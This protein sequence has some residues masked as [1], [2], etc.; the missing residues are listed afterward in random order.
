[1]NSILDLLGEDLYRKGK[2]PY[3][4]VNDTDGQNDEEAAKEAWHKHLLRNESIITDL[5]H[6]QFKSTVCC[7]SCPR[8]SV[9]FD[10]SMTILLPIPSKKQ[11]I[12]FFFIPYKIKENYDNYC[13]EVAV[14][15]TDSVLL[16]R[17]ALHEKY[18]LECNNFVIAEVCDNEF[19]QFTNGNR[20]VEHINYYK[21]V[22]LL[23]E[24]NPAFPRDEP[25]FSA[26]KTDNNNGFD[27][28]ITK[29]VLE[30]Q[31]QNSP[32]TTKYGYY[33]PKRDST[34]PRLMWVEKAWT[35][36]DLHFEI[37][38]Y[39]R[40]IIQEWMEWTCPNT[41]RKPKLGKVDLRKELLPFPY[42]PQNWPQDQDFDTDEF[43]K[44]SDEEAYKCCF[45]N[46]VS[47]GK[48][49]DL[50]EWS[51]DEMPYQVCFK[52]VKGSYD[53]CEYCSK[54]RCHSCQ[55]PFC[56]KTT[57]GEVLKRL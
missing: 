18:G 49:P 1:M 4:E 20:T 41:E 40:Q 13:C 11:I 3:V 27:E 54:T 5:F 15:D 50:G 31:I 57:I 30:N 34:L 45:P 23:Y 42:R 29:L 16:L 32:N 9:T 25:V 55:V 51:I 19:V 6:G 44:L 39:L 33:V 24:V 22:K 26:D 10:P 14:R 36:S 7:S 56:N 8:V 47:E 21:G 48:M 12:K 35:M 37:F 2:K 43:K 28:K 38:K 53:P 17:Q 52:N 46:L